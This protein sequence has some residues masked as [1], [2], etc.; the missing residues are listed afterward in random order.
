G[1]RTRARSRRA[2]RKSR[3][4]G[5]GGEGR[6]ERERDGVIRSKAKR[7]PADFWDPAKNAW[8]RSPRGLAEAVEGRTLFRAAR[9]PG[10]SVQPRDSRLPVPCRAGRAD[11]LHFPRATPPSIA[12]SS[13]RVVRA[14][15]RCREVGPAG[16]L[17]PILATD[18]PTL[19]PVRPFLRHRTHIHTYT[20]SQ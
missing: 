4:E 15:L 13:F 9:A 6:R 12:L 1:P 18:P 10:P 7:A 20:Y 19:A 17:R 2:R 14:S 3:A 16:S 11:Q 5:R 8:A